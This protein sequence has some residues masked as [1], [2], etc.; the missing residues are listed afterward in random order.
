MLSCT[1][2]AMAIAAGCCF[3]SSAL[4]STPVSTSVRCCPCPAGTWVQLQDSHS[5]YCINLLAASGAAG[6]KPQAAYVCAT[7]CW[8]WH[9]N[10]PLPMHQHSAS[11]T[12]TGPELRQY[13][14]TV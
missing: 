6:L 3:H 14:V 10:L 11:Q 5:A 2:R 9:S 7:Y 8:Q 13:S 1:M 4:P 12:Q